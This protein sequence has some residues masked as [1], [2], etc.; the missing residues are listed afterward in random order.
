ML[1]DMPSYVGRN[2]ALN[3]G[4]PHHL[5]RPSLHQWVV[6]L[7][8]WVKLTILYFCCIDGTTSMAVKCVWTQCNCCTAAEELRTLC[9]LQCSIGLHALSWP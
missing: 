1:L 8:W 6:T 9:Y 4:A 7:L 3:A 2:E 5:P